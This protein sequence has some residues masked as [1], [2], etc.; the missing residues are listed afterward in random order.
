[1]KSG[2]FVCAVAG[3]HLEALLGVRGSGVIDASH[4]VPGDIIA[5]D[6]GGGT[7]KR[8]VLSGG[9]VLHTAALNIGAR[10]IAW[11]PASVVNHMD[12][13]GAAV[14]KAIG[15]D[16]NV[17]QKLEEAQ[18]KAIA[19]RM[20]QCLIQFLG[21]EPMDALAQSLFLTVSAPPPFRPPYRLVFLG[22]VS[23]YFYG[24]ETE[25]MGDLGLELSEAFRQLL[26]EHVSPDQV[27]EWDNG[28]RAT[29]TGAG[30]FTMQISSETVWLDPRFQLP[31]RS[32]PVYGVPLDWRNLDPASV[33]DLL[34]LVLQRR[35]GEELCALSFTAAPSYGYGAVYQLVDALAH[36]LPRIGL[37]EGIVLVFRDN[38]ARIAGGALDKLLP[39]VP[40]LCIDEVEV[41]DFE[42]L[43]IGAPPAGSAYVPVVVKSLVFS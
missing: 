2:H 22:G 23:E 36:V 26:R 20:A 39:E 1:M 34:S 38:I 15:I 31:L 12:T 14:A 6:I 29:V 25:P 7:A 9:K 30:Q 13:A 43:D 17:G 19:R 24:R 33:E 28:I 41:G 27:L 5:L 3:H 35:E 37:Q 32:V 11:D 42:Y 16:V 8:S 18:H 21:F 10:L 40:V 4:A